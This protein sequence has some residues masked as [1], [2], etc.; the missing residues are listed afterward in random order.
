MSGSGRQPKFKLRRSPGSCT[1]D[2]SAEVDIARD[3]NPLCPAALAVYFPNPL[4]KLLV[5]TQFCRRALQP[6]RAAYGAGEEPVITLCARNKPGAQTPP[7]TAGARSWEQKGGDSRPPLA[8]AA[9]ADPGTASS[10]R[11]EPFP[12]G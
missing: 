11:T 4:L 8:A 12:G 10:C 9:L 1:P 5:Q 7:L 6:L 2:V 3:K